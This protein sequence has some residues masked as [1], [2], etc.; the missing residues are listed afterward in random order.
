MENKVMFDRL[1]AGTILKFGKV[2]S[3]DITLIVKDIDSVFEVDIDK[4]DISKYFVM[5]NG[6]ILLNEDYVNYIYKNIN[7]F[8]LEKMSV[9][10]IARYFDNLDIEN[11]V[12]RKINLLGL[13]YIPKDDLIHNFSV[14]QLHALKNLYEK[15]YVLDYLHK[16]LIYGDYCAVKISKIGIIKLFVDDNYM[17]VNRFYKTLIDL[18]IDVSML[19]NYLMSVN[20][21]VDIMDILDTDN[22]LD[23]CENY[24]KK[25]DECKNIENGFSRKLIN[26]CQQLLFLEIIFGIMQLDGECRYE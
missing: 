26:G 18:K 1:V 21:N 10:M 20:L 16:D 22:Y 5:R 11:F 4:E 8:L 3:A 13:G 9:N 17:M 23:F 2:D 6:N 19:D 25:I 12:L 14:I 7:N 24:D 15:G